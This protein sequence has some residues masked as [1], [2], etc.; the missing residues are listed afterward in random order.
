M[1]EDSIFHT[2]V[3]V[4]T[5][6]QTFFNLSILKKSRFPQKKFITLT[7]GLK[8]LLMGRHG[9]TIYLEQQ[10]RKQCVYDY[11]LCQ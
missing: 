8:S 3:Q 5:S 6:E 4:P 11:V 1:L 2:L 10:F 9:D 7:T